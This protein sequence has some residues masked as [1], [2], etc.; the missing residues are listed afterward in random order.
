MLKPIGLPAWCV[1]PTPSANFR[2]YDTGDDRVRLIT[3]GEIT[4]MGD[5]PLVR[6]HSSCLASEVFGAQD[7]DCADQ[8]RESLRLIAREGAG[9]VFHLDQEGRGHGLAVKIDAVGR[10]QRDYLD[11]VEAMESLGLKQDTRTYI[12]VAE[13]LRSLGVGRVRLITNNPAKIRFFRERG[14][15]VQVVHTHP[16]VRDENIGYLRAKNAKLGHEL[17]LNDHR[18]TTGTIRFLHSD[19]AYGWLSNFSAHA[20]Y[21][22]GVVWPT[23]EHFYQ[24]QKF[25][26]PQQR[27]AI[28]VCRSPTLAK[29]AAREARSPRDPAWPDI[30]DGVMAR[31]VRAKFEQHPDLADKLR[32]TGLRPIIE[33]S[34]H[35]A[36]WGDG[37]DGQGLNALGRLLMRVR[38][39]LGGRGHPDRPDLADPKRCEA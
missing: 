18:K 33:D 38:Q 16:V 2:M 4:E 6:V 39:E 31:G 29:D 26:S 15:G 22:E 14:L 19:Q 13:V 24:A 27:E 3:L 17:E 5:V 34:P 25:E 7:C 32:D 36:Y 10:S 28:R 20:I 21:A 12:P 11:T 8:L 35:D 37:G 30:K 9:M 23:V 1:L